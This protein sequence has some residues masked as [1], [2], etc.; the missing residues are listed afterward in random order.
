MPLN[1][2]TITRQ[3]IVHDTR[4]WNSVQ[5]G[6]MTLLWLKR[7]EITLP[8][9]AYLLLLL[10]FFFKFKIGRVALDCFSATSSYFVVAMSPKHG[11]PFWRAQTKTNWGQ[12][13]KKNTVIFWRNE[14]KYKSQML[15]STCCASESI[16]TLPASKVSPCGQHWAWIFWVSGLHPPQTVF[17]VV[18]DKN[19]CALSATK[20]VMTAGLAT[21]ELRGM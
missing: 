17:I 2:I 15:L 5:V 7:F 9:N 14:T 20:A 13:E 4:G 10:F 8:F 11:F 6:K 3:Q 18:S 21:R 19:S 1:T 12:L 16:C